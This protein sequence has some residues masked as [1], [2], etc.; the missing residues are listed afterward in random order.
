MISIEASVLQALC[1]MLTI[2]GKKLDES[3]KVKDK[4]NGYFKTM[5]KLGNEKKL[6][7]R[8]RFLIRDVLDLR[9]MKWV[10]RR[11]TLKVVP[12]TLYPIRYSLSPVPSL[13]MDACWHI[14]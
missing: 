13:F 14:R 4:V 3:S 1:E 6:A 12:Y 2:A 7:P 9:R 8:I 10:P 5:D 11:E